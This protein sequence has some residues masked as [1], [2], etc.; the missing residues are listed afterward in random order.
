MLLLIAWL[1]I[2]LLIGPYEE[3][4]YSII[5]HWLVIL[6]FADIRNNRVVN[7][8]EKRIAI[9]IYFLQNYRD[10]K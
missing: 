8:T 4:S 10:N 5:V 1:V 9:P 3:Y 7:E 6:L 2:L